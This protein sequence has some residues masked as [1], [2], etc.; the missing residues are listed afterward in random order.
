M[1]FAAQ[2]EG[3]GINSSSDSPSANTRLKGKH[4]EPI[5]ILGMV[6]LTDIDRLRA[7]G[8]TGK[9]FIACTTDAIFMD[10]KDMYDLFIDLTT[11]T[12]DKSSRPTLYTT[13]FVP[14][15]GPTAPAYYKFS[16]IRFSWSDVKLV[17]S[18]FFR[19]NAL[20]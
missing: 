18:V 7:E 11:S 17:S 10:K 3:D 8:K 4:K 1:C 12:P 13:K 20:Y 15:E 14:A 6:T 16:N 5:N 19:S 2:A 9:G